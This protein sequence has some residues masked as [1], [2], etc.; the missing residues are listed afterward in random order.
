MDDLSQTQ[1][2]LHEKTKTYKFEINYVNHEPRTKNHYRCRVPRKGKE[3]SKL[4]KLNW[5]E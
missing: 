1:I 3:T 4:V 2:S 5:Q